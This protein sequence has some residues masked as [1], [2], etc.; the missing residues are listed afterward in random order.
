[1]GSFGSPFYA[2]APVITMNPQPAHQSNVA[3]PSGASQASFS[4]NPALDASGAPLTNPLGMPARGRKRSRDEAAPNLVD[5]ATE[6]M[7]VGL[8]ANAEQGRDWG[9]G[10]GTE[11]MKSRHDCITNASNQSGAR[12]DGMG[13]LNDVQQA[14]STPAHI[15]AP[16]R[17]PLHSN[18][19]Q[20]LDQG[21]G[22]LPGVEATSTLGGLMPTVASNGAGLM[23][24]G[25]SGNTSKQPVIDDFTLHLGIGWRKI[26]EDDHLQAAAR[27]WARY[28]ENHYPLTSVN[29]RLE[30]RGLQA[31]LVEAAEGFF[32]FAEDLKQGRLVSTQAET[33]F[34]NLKTSPPSFEGQ[35]SLFANEN[36]QSGAQPMTGTAR[37]DTDMETSA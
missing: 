19:S 10:E 18:K 6:P 4:A 26:S 3:M 8:P 36:P 14:A 27:G 32:L 25:A 33:A 30:S 21:A 13:T 9:H 29:I 16:E 15:S 7:S 24:S 2:S 5:E 28:I 35:S 22:E 37:N 31:Y 20:R 34:Q 23:A 17:P 12:L 11:L 1:M